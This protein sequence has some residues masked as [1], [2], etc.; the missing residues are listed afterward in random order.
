MAVIHDTTMTPTKRELLVRWL[1]GQPWFGGGAEELAR[2]GGFRLDDPA[3]EVG[4]EF[5]VIRVADAAY[6]VPMSYRG[7]PLA[8]AEAGLIG[9]SEHGVLGP[10]W[11][12]DG[13]QDPVLQAQLAA[14]VR[15]ETVAQAQGVS[16]T[17]DPT[18]LVGVAAGASAVP[19]RRRLT[20][21]DRPPG[22]GQ[23]SAPWR[24]ADG[25]TARGMV[26]GG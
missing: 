22:P 12:Y 10:R 8:G 24:R 21:D 11:I 17:P 5:V 7:A 2:A 13:E 6:L 14:L 23:V 26:A 25:S 20:E 18:V 16:N 9:T 4:L 19:I 3:G 1:P 15:G